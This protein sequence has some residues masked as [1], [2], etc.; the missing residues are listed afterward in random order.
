MESL[1]DGYKKY[2]DDV[3]E[4]DK[5]DVVFKIID[6]YN[7]P[8]AKANLYINI[9]VRSRGVLGEYKRGNQTIL[10][11]KP[12]PNDYKMTKEEEDVFG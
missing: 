11:F 1:Q 7:V 5:K 2:D 8:Q 10:T 6:T 9:L 12:K 3:L 4:M